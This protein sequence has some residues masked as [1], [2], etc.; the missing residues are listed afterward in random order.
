[1]NAENLSST[2][3]AGI[4]DHDVIVFTGDSG[5]ESLT[6]VLRYEGLTSCRWMQIPHRGSIYNITQSLSSIF[7]S[8][9]GIYFGG[10][11]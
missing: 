6:R 7:P 8:E 5:N 1:M 10:W 9:D 11:N 4:Y 2:I 3:L